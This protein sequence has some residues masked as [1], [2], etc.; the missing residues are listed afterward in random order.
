MTCRPYEDRFTG[1]LGSPEAPLRALVAHAVG[2]TPGW[3]RAALRLRDRIVAP[4]GLKTARGHDG[5][6]LAMMTTF[7][8]SAERFTTGL[9]DR[10]LDFRVT[11][12]R[13]AG[14]TFV[15]ATRVEPHTAFGWLYLAA[16]LPAHRLI[17]RGYARTLA[18]P[19]PEASP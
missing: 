4:L 10:H 2:R 13:E 11:L 14:G 9:D 16:V 7:E 5:P 12:A 1:T 3:A 19:L 17:M 15:L 6:L 8:D 18:R